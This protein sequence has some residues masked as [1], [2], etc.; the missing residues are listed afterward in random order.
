MYPE[1][2][3]VQLGM[4]G[5]NCRECYIHCEQIIFCRTVTRKLDD[6]FFYSKTGKLIAYTAV[7]IF[8]YDAY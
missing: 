5:C 1:G 6:V 4:T 3:T 2:T 7:F 8:T